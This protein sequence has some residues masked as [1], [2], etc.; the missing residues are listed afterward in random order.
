MTH[1]PRTLLR[2]WLITLAI[3]CLMPV[4]G[5]L[6]GKAGDCKPDQVDGQCG[7]STFIM[8][9]YGVVIGLLIM[10]TV[11]VYVILATLRYRKQHSPPDS[12]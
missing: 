8:L 10:I 6:L 2:V 9:Q 12:D 3:S 11:T 7:M 4:A 1:R 5:D